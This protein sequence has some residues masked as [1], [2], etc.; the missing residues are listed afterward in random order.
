MIGGARMRPKVGLITIGQS[1]RPDIL[2]DIRVI[3]GQGPEVIMVGALDSFSK[4]EV[5]SLISSSSP[6]KQGYF[7][8]RLRDGTLVTV[9]KECIIERIGSALQ[10]L[11]NQDVRL[12]AILCMGDYPAYPYGG[13]FLKPSEI[14]MQLITSFQDNEKGVI[15]IPL[16]EERQLANERWSLRN[17]GSRIMVLPI[18]SDWNAVHSLSEEIQAVMPTFVLLECMGYDEHLK[19]HLKEKVNCPVI[20][21]KTLLAYI[22]KGFI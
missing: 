8:T 17:V 14:I 9:P 4:E 12:A 19:T 21:P 10:K 2:D 6:S 20:L 5:L 18:G 16:E 22:L 11:E 3:L 7:V 15:V 13:I 1:P